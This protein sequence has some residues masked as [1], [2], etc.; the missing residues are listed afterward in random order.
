M[1]PT[2]CYLC[3]GNF[4]EPRDTIDVQLGSQ[5]PTESICSLQVTVLGLDGPST[6][7]H[8][9]LPSSYP[10]LP[11]G[12]VGIITVPSATSST[13]LMNSPKSLRCQQHSKWQRE[14]LLS[15]RACHCSDQ[16]DYATNIPSHLEAAFEHFWA[17]LAEWLA[18]SHFPRFESDQRF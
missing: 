2:V 9:D 16:Q 5:G 8:M 7:I 14:I 3:M 4:D 17:Q 12:P 13:T 10:T 18:T 11:R 1:I 15:C 6:D